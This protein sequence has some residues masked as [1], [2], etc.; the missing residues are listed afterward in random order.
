MLTPHAS[1]ND[2]HCIRSNAFLNNQLRVMNTHSF[3]ENQF[4][5]AM[6][7]NVF[8]FICN[9]YEELLL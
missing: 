3:Q 2:I 1:V 5:S 7:D 8:L 4:S 9:M 6:L